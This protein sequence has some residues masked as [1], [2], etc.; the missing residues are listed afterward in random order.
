M[1][2]FPIIQWSA[3]QAISELI[4]GT[5]EMQERKSGNAELIDTQ[6]QFKGCV[7]GYLKAKQVIYVK[8]FLRRRKLKLNK[9][10]I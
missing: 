7:S 5:V 4:A 3:R 10:K 9:F 6:G 8:G 2:H 1:S